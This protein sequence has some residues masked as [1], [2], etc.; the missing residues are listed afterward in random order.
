MKVFIS[1]SGSKSGEIAQCLKDWLP[2]VIQAVKPYFTPDDMEKGTR[3]NTEIST[4]LEQSKIGL[5]ILTPE[6]IESPWIMFESGAL[7]KKVD[8]AKVCPILFRLE[9]TDIKGPLAQFQATKFSKH[10]IKKVVETIN[11]ALEDGKLLTTTLNSVFDKWWDDLEAKVN[12]IV[13]KEITEKKSTIRS[14][15][16]ILEEILNI[17]RTIL[18][19][20]PRPSRSVNSAA[21]RDMALTL[22]VI[23]S[24]CKNI[25]VTTGLRD[26]FLNIKKP[27]VYLLNF[28]DTETGK[29]IEQLLMRI[30][31]LKISPDDIPF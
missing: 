8:S 10:E 18:K 13:S 30:E 27:L 24:E 11:N 4:E 26:A 7:S 29:V 3:W 22:N 20:N 23:V 17:S 28:G 2:N 9:P 1:W 25:G 16:E 31:N 15:R 12:G 21:I 19:T 5:I 14:E 6:N